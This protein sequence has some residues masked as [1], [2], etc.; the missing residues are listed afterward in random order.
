[1]TS[2]PRTQVWWPPDKVRTRRLMALMRGGRMLA[3]QRVILRMCER[4]IEQ[5]QRD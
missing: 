4:A 5:R 1:M 3:A 2:L